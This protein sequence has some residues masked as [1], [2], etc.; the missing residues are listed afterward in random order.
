M[1][2]FKQILKEA[3]KFKPRTVAVAA[4][5]DE[6]VILGIHL[7]QEEKIANGILIGDKEKISS[8]FKKNRLN[9]ENFKVIHESDHEKASYKALELI[10]IKKAHILMKGVVKTNIL[11]KCVLNKDLGISTGATLSHILALEL[12][13][14]DKLL[15]ITDGGMIIKPEFED[16]KHIIFNAVSAAKGL[17][18]KNPKIAI[19]SY[20][21]ESLE[22]NP[23][24][25]QA[26]L[27][28]K[29]DIEGVK[30][31]GPKPLERAINLQYSKE[32]ND[33]L[34]V[35]DIETGN[36]LGKALM[37]FAE[38]RSG[39]VV[40]GAKVPIVLTSRADSKETRLNSI[41]MAILISKNKRILCLN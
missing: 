32:S 40:M 22:E 7:A 35:P 10:R 39:L 2:N 4:A 3:K 29:L 18:I 31:F 21:Y 17:K 38:P 11:M 36:I 20:P 26:A 1:K 12:K 6:D 5:E 25:S 34:I 15:F 19:L 30:I 41:A 13:P 9:P 23:M 14:Y 16:K 28:S 33:I 24:L 8:I 37:Y 27:L